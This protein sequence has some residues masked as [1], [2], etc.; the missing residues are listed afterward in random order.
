MTRYYSAIILSIVISSLLLIATFYFQLS[1]PTARTSWVYESYKIK[2]TA[3]KLRE[4]NRRLFVVSGSSSLY[5]VG[6][7][8]IERKLGVPTVNLG[9]HAGLNIQ[10][11]LDFV[12]RIANPG[13]TVL[14]TLE[15]QKYTAAGDRWNTISI[16]YVT[17]RDEEYYHELPLLDKASIIRK[18]GFTRILQGVVDKYVSRPGMNPLDYHVLNANGDETNNSSTPATIQRVA[19][20]SAF[21][22]D[23]PDEDRLQVIREFIVWAQQNNVN[24]IATYP[25]LF[26]LD[27]YRSSAN[28]MFFDKIADFW[29]S[30]GV[31]TLGTP[32]DFMYPKAL[33]YNSQYHLNTEGTT[34]HTNKLIG[35]L[36]ESE[37]LK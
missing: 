22:F 30:N 3:A 35:F 26:N 23:D 34:L 24:V 33:M 32:F 4:G 13:D 29:E 9:T 18:I 31:T 36:R 15:Y 5:S 25:P 2:T 14:L 17:S 20:M 16:D 11:L 6:T 21:R 28:S 10:Y 7:L 1:A 19:A 8:D 12:K 37:A 27:E